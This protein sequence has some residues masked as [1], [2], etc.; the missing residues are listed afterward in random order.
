MPNRTNSE[1]TR[2]STTLREIWVFS[3]KWFLGVWAHFIWISEDKAD[4]NSHQT[5]CIL[6][7]GHW[8]AKDLNRCHRT[9]F[10]Q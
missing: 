6:W 7:A 1:V 9:C 8:H 5:L 10:S 3:H 2:R 4:C